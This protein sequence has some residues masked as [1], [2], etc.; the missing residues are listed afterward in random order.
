MTRLAFVS[1]SIL[2]FAQAAA[3][4]PT[5]SQISFA[6]TASR[7]PE[8]LEAADELMSSDVGKEF[9]GKLLLQ[10]NTVDGANPAT[11]SFVPIYKT[12]A[13]REAFVRKLQA[14][15]AWEKFLGEMEESAESVATILYQVVQSWGELDEADPV[16][17][18]HMFSVSDASAFLEAIEEF[19]ATET[20]KQFPGQVY[21]SAVVAAG[22]SPVTHVISVGYASEAEMAT[23]VAKRN[24]TKDWQKYLDASDP[25]SE[26]LGAA[27]A[28]TLETWGPATFE[29][30]VAP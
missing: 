6:T 18:A 25:V 11:H 4:T 2:L 26:Y 22:L 17:I 15:E 20:G 24:A 23:W 29:E 27:M 16:W 9:E 1:A 5:W 28:R 13:D 8:I 14:S 10:Q 21:L 30:L 7:A 3:A 19:L 12:A